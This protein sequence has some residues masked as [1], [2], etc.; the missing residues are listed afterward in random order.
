[1]ANDGEFK[2]STVSHQA[3]LKKQLIVCVTGPMAAGK[4]MAS[5]ILADRGF[6]TIDADELAHI[7]VENAKDKILSAF[8]PL[9]NERNIELTNSDGTINRRAVGQLIFA[10]KALVAKQESIVF[11][12]INRLFD[13]FIENNRDRDIAINATVLYKVP[14][15]NKVD[16]I[17][18]IDAPKIQR[19][20]R[21]RRR[22]KMPA[23]Q[24][25]QRFSQQRT[26]F[27]KYKNCNADIRRVWNIGTRRRLETKID[28]FLT[29]CR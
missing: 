17:L 2:Q 19:Y 4:N 16:A 14:L 5:E 3:S 12:E 23:K 7:A 26:L 24:I 10:D 28:Q 25:K 15:I 18:Y 29:T 20:F 8:L 27:A 13:E 1:M 11:P 6:A 21:A 22:D 9:A